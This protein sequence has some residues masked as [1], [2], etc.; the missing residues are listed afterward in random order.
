MDEP[1][2]EDIIIESFNMLQSLNSLLEKSDSRGGGDFVVDAQ[3]GIYDF[4]VANQ[5]VHFMA[6]GMCRLSQSC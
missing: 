1:F 5:L 4:A 3:V 2:V 6:T